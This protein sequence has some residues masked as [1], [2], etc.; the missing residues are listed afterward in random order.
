VEQ[1][2]V[3]RPVLEERVDQVI[4]IAT[5]TVIAAAQEAVPEE[6]HQ[7]AVMHVRDDGDLSEEVRLADGSVADDP[8][9]GDR[10]AVVEHAT[11]DFGGAAAPH[12]ATEVS[13]HGS[14]LLVRERPRQL[15]DAERGVLH[16]FF[17]FFLL[18]R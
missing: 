11:E 9:D 3:Q 18:N 14:D 16:C 12:H 7:A 10:G 4:V 2:P 8:L 6:A 5:T 1:P 13:G 15:L 17:F